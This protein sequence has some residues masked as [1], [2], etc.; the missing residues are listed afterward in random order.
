MARDNDHNCECSVCAERYAL[1][2]AARKL[3]ECFTAGMTIAIGGREIDH[4]DLNGARQRLQA[5]LDGH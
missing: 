1:K 2:I 5:L 3:V 4:T